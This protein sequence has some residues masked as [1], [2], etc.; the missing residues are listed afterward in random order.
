[1]IHFSLLYTGIV[2]YIRALCMYKGK[3]GHLLAESGHL[4][5][6]SGHTNTVLREVVGVTKDVFVILLMALPTI[7][8]VRF[9]PHCCV[10]RVARA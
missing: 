3:S 9:L 4:L 5:A 10:Q 7:P 1:M 6:Q 2:Y 8:F